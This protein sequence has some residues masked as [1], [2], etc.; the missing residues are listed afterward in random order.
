MALRAPRLWALAWVLLLAAC[1]EPTRL[2]PGTGRAEVLSQLGT[3]TATYPL[4]QGERLQYSRAPLGT[5]VNNVDLDAAGKVVA[6]TQV[7]DERRFAARHPGRYVWRRGRRAAH[8]R[9]HPK[10]SAA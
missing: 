1:A 10:K 4:G 6:V 3:P 8:L 7:L 9:A 5:A 2:P